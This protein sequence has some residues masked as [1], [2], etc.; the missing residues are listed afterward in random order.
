MLLP[1]Y[2]KKHIEAGCDEAGRGCYAGP[3]FASAVILHRNFKHPILND[4][5]QL[6]EKQRNELRIIIENEAVCYGVAMV[7]N[8]EIDKINILKAS[9]KAMHLA[10]ESLARQPKYLIIDGNYFLHYQNVQHQ[11]IVKGDGL[12]A[13]IAAASVLAKTHRDEYL[14]NIHH[15]FPMYNWQRNKGYGTAEHRNAIE[16]HG[17]CKYHRMSFNI[18]KNVTI[19][20]P[21]LR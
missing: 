17:L 5:K 8:E 18:Q 11:C 20:S 15:E 1:Y 21:T 14:C 12:Y 2:Q 19:Q 7:T 10:L 6:T 3:V 16:S 13:S 4:S 9:V